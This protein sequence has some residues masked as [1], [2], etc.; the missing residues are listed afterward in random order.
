MKGLIHPHL[1]VSFTAR[2]DE[3][4][5]MILYSRGSCCKYFVL[6]FQCQAFL[7]LEGR[8]FLALPTLLSFIKAFFF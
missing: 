6:P 4:T 7:S 2:N 8:L 1:N 5:Y 3:C